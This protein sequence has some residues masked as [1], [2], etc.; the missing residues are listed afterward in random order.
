MT[1]YHENEESRIKI[2]GILMEISAIE[3]TLGK[4][5]T[6]EE[7]RAAKNKQIKLH[8]E[9]KNIDKEF[10]DI[11]VGNED[12]KRNPDVID[13]FKKTFSGENIKKP[14]DSGFAEWIKRVFNISKKED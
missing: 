4:D 7:K 11:I 8:D 12:Q 5:S 10:Y 1:I 14:L 2:D 3:C 13:F 6:E 9:I